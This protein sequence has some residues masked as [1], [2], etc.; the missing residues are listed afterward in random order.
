MRCVAA[1]AAADVVLRTAAGTTRCSSSHAVTPDVAEYTVRARQFLEF[2]RKGVA[3][4]LESNPSMKVELLP[5][6]KGD[7]G[8]GSIGELRV[9][10]SDDVGTYTFQADVPAQEL[11]MISPQTGCV[12]VQ[13]G[14]VR[15]IGCAAPSLCRCL[16]RM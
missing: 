3:D 2:L 10:V 14:G 7:G 16:A 1:A 5:P 4:M 13:R 9:F 8:N 15:M 6:A 12:H 11:V